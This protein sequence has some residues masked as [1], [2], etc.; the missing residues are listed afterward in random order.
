MPLATKVLN[1]LFE[2]RCLQGV[3]LPL[4]FRISLEDFAWQKTTL[5]ILPPIIQ[6]GFP[7]LQW[8]TQFLEC[9]LPS[10]L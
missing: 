6:E 4:G 3:S 9:S 1:R 8:I 7:L 5:L 10:S 2:L